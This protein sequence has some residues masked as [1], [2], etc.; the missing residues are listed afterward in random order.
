MGTTKQNLVA[1]VTWCSEF[2]HPWFV[3]IVAT[4]IM[5]ILCCLRLKTPQYFAGWLFLCVIFNF[6]FYF[7]SYLLWPIMT[8]GLT[9]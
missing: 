4:E 8:T 7:Y 6:N 9:M 3:I 1:C 2:V 5:D